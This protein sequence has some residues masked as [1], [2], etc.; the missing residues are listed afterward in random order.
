MPRARNTRVCVR[1]TFIDPLRSL[2][3]TANSTTALNAVVSL[4]GPH[5]HRRSR[6]FTALPAPRAVFSIDI[7]TA[8]R[9]TIT[10]S[11]ECLRVWDGSEDDLREMESFEFPNFQNR[12]ESGSFLYPR[13]RFIALTNDGE[14]IREESAKDPSFYVRANFT[15]IFFALSDTSVVRERK[16]SRVTC[17]CARLFTRGE[18]RRCRK[19]R[20]FASSTYLEPLYGKF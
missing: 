20:A 14:K 5:G 17:L 8:E 4:L 7:S 16:K 19:R 12:F 6:F 18:T 13:G 9:S 1:N 10:F 3:S 2:A 15:A 11:F